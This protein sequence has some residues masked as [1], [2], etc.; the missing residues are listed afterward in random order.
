MAKT[1]MGQRKFLETLARAAAA[2]HDVDVVPVRHLTGK[3]L[4]GA[5]TKAKCTC[6]WESS[7]RSRRVRAVL[8]AVYHA[9]EV[10]LVLDERGRLDLV[11]WSAAP[12]AHVLHQ[13]VEEALERTRHAVPDTG[14]PDLSHPA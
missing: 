1:T 5:G 3:H 4:S 10:C 12:N 6:G 2:G 9:L 7:V 11:E 13:G 8:A 14:S